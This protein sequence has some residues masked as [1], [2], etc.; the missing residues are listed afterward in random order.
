MNHDISLGPVVAG[1]DGSA[2]ARAAVLWAAEEAQSRGQSLHLVHATGTDKHVLHTTA[3]SL[4]GVQEAGRDLLAET[5]E[6]VAERYPAVAVTTELSPLD[7]VAALREAAGSEG[8]VVVGSR[9]LGGFGALLLGS[10]SLGVSAGAKV[11][12]MV[13]RGEDTDE[14]ASAGTV[15]VA[16]VR[17]Q[18]DLPWARYAAHEASLRKAGLRLLTVWAPLSHVGTELTLLDDIDGVA[19]ERVHEIGQLAG[20]LREEFP[21]LDVTTEVEG[22]RSVPGLLVESTRDAALLVLGAHRPPLGIGHALG[23]VTH[24]VLH[25]AHCPVAIIPRAPRPDEE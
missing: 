21:D 10:V 23:H 11:P 22:A 15:V 14:P 5:A 16:A 4:E 20:T 19:K 7:A 24:A 9:G 25:H 3:A 18:D 17:G 2:R 6:L 8:T 1:V 12:V 13:V